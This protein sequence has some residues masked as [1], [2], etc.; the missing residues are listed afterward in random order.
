[1]L[2]ERAGYDFEVVAPDLDEPAQDAGQGLQPAQAAEAI[3]YFKARSV[4]AMFPDR[5]ILAADTVVCAGGRIIGKPRDADDARKILREISSEPHT[6][7]TGVALLEPGEER[8]IASDT[9]QVT[10]R[11]MSDEEIEDYIASGEW[12]GKAGAYAIQETADRF[13][14]K[15]EGSYTNVVGLP[16]ELVDRMISRIETGGGEES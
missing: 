12:E 6:V 3:A 5:R 7:V 16:M 15:V 2:L 10:M 1:V 11:P 9:T 8:L 14:E 13:V 4:A